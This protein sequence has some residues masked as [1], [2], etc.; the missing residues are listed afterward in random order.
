[1]AFVPVGGALECFG[2]AQDGLFAE[3][4]SDQLETDGHAG[5]VPTARD[6]DR[7]Q[8]GQARRVGENVDEAIV[9]ISKVFSA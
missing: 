2:G 7:R 1:M 6:D 3:G 8:T 4:R 5:L 9:R